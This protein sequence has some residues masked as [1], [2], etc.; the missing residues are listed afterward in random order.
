MSEEEEEKKEGAPN[1]PQYGFIYLLVNQEP[2]GLPKE[3]H[4]TTPLH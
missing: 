3:A 2:H 4:V 1:I